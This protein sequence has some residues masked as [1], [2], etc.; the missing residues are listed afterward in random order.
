MKQER[1]Y[2]NYRMEWIAETLRVF[3]YINREHLVRKFGLSTPQASI[4]LRD[5]QKLHPNAVTYNLT[6]K[7]YAAK[8]NKL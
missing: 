7:R 3:G 1:W 6:A 5:F 2:K 8:E 4:D